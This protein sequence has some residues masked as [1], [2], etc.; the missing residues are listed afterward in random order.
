MTAEEKQKVLQELGGIPEEFYDELLTEFKK[1]HTA[2]IVEIREALGGGDLAKARTAAH[3]LSGSAANLRLY[4][5]HQAA[6]A[7]ELSLKEAQA[8]DVIDG[9]FKRLEAI[10]PENN[11]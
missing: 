6:K 5:T 11:E 4:K 2:Q 10:D 1:Q 8:R 3:S 9:N 7:L